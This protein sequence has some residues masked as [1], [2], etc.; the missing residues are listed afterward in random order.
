MKEDSGRYQLSPLSESHAIQFSGWR[1]P[2][3]YDCY[4]APN[5]SE[6]IRQQWAICDPVKR[7]GQFTALILPSRPDQLVGFV[8]LDPKRVPGTLV[9]SCGLRPDKCGVGL[10]GVLVAQAASQSVE[11]QR[12]IGLFVRKFNAR[13]IHLYRTCGFTEAAPPEPTAMIWMVRNP[14]TTQEG[15]ELDHESRF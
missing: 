2:A 14:K 10:G 6:M 4:D 1:Y 7:A 15:G 11:Q 12:P 13:A 5:W 9:V 3:P 8:R